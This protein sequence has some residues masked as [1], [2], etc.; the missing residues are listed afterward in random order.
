M[1]WPS[2]AGH[3]PPLK[4]GLYT[5]H[6]P[7]MK[8]NFAF[9]SGYY[10]EVASK[11]WMVACVSFSQLCSPMWFRSVQALYMLP[12]LLWVH[13]WVHPLVSRRPYFLGVFLS[14][15]FTIFLF[16]LLQNSLK[17]EGRVLMK[18]TNLGLSG[19][20]SPILC[21]LSSCASPYLFPFTA[22]ANLSNYGWGRPWSIGIA[23]CIYEL[24]Y[25]YI[26]LAQ[27]LCLF[28]FPLHPLPM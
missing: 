3:R 25:W 19:P 4:C 28:C 26:P 27:Q 7:L 17:P 2:I 5:F 23:E 22:E 12:Q 21:T 16:L 20:R 14:Q 10:L 1:Y 13:I 15:S 24:F 9:A 11:L 8:I 6:H 18:I